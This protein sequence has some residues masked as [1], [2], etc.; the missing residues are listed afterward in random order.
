MLDQ[1]RV[2][3][4]DVAQV[5]RRRREHEMPRACPLVVQLPVTLGEGP[6]DGILAAKADWCSF[7][8]KRC[9]GEGLARCPA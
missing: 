2:V 9:E 4:L 7:R 5:L 6:T 1:R 3:D 8:K